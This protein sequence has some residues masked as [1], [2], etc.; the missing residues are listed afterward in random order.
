MEASLYRPLGDSLSSVIDGI[1]IG[2]VKASPCLY[3]T[4]RSHSVC[5]RVFHTQTPV[6]ELPAP[7]LLLECPRDVFGSD[8]DTVMRIEAG[9]REERELHVS[10]T[11]WSQSISMRF[12]DQLQLTLRGSEGTWHQRARAKA[13]AFTV[14]LS[15]VRVAAPA[16]AARACA[17]D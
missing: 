10:Y 7:N 17:R 2:I 4:P 8:E 15:V 11:D 14:R 9:G 1:R 3:L 12:E 6:L 16:A 13:A 5:G